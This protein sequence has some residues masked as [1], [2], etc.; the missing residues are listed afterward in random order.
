[1]TSLGTGRVDRNRRA[2]SGSV[3]HTG[4]HASPLCR[5]W[6]MH[7]EWQAGKRA[8]QVRHRRGGGT[9]ALPTTT[10]NRHVSPHRQTSPTHYTVDG[11]MWN[12]TQPRWKRDRS[13]NTPSTPPPS[14]HYYSMQK[15]PS[16]L[17]QSTPPF[18]TFHSPGQHPPYQH[19]H[20]STTC[21]VPGRETLT[22]PTYVNNN[23][24]HIHHGATPTLVDELLADFTT[25]QL[26][27]L[28]PTM[29]IG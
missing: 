1:M 25:D 26:Q 21:P 24:S 10:P 13:P 20:R 3:E 12:V 6:G 2:F 29:S 16:L 28:T 9:I 17:T 7:R 22:D 15:A 19:T 5:W 14:A 23:K 4:Q 27:C 8:G 11:R 18:N